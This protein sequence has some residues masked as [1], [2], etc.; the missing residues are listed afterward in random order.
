MHPHLNPLP[1]TP[2]F[3][4][5]PQPSPLLSSS[6][7]PSSSSSP[8]WLMLK[9]A[10]G[11]SAVSVAVDEHEEMESRLLRLPLDWLP[12]LLLRFEAEV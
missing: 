12:L 10:W 1:H 4:I 2:P 6:S 11:V 7:L 3:P 9:V 8:L 5:L